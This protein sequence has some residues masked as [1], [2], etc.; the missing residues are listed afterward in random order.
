MMLN[1]KI[2]IPREKPEWKTL[3]GMFPGGELYER[4][5]ADLLGVRFEGLPPGLRYPLP[6]DWP[7]NEFPL[8][9]DWKPTA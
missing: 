9:K 3:I 5:I 8:R 1:L 7:D 6:D 4:E 2:S